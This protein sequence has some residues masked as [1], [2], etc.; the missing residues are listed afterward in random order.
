MY[1]VC[2]P[3]LLVMASCQFGSAEQEVEILP[4]DSVSM[5]TEDRAEASEAALRERAD[6]P[7]L[8][9]AQ[10]GDW[11]DAQGEASP[12]PLNT[13]LFEQRARTESALQQAKQALEAQRRAERDLLQLQAAFVQE[14][15]QRV[16]LE[17]ERA[18]LLD[19]IGE[20]EASL[21]TVFEGQLQSELLKEQIAKLEVELY[22]SKIY[23]PPL[24]DLSLEDAL[25]ATRTAIAKLAEQQQ[26]LE[27]FQTPEG[28]G[29]RLNDRLIFG[30]GQVELDPEGEELL[31]QIAQEFGAILKVGA[32]LQ[33]IGHTDNQP[34]V[35]QLHRFPLGNL[36]LSSQR[37]LVVANLLIESGIPAAS[38]TISGYGSWRPLASNETAEGRAQNR[39]VEITLQV[40]EGISSLPGPI[41]S[42]DIVDSQ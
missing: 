8:P 33:V 7:R 26:D 10:I 17:Q 38:M 36:Q 1:R 37:A 27:W 24:G 40:P 15:G 29:L 4:E 41:K 3:A 14:R 31:R 12:T 16:E 21:D 6:E 34:L 2:L 39:R 5:R 32:T 22:E 11:V 23:Q 20:F 19:R 9:Q 25:R 18:F 30:P 13:Q 28:A 42:P 35:N